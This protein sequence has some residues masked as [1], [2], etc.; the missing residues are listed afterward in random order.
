MLEPLM[1]CFP[2]AVLLSYWKNGGSFSDVA[3]SFSL[4]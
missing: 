2:S 4:W 1:C 3:I